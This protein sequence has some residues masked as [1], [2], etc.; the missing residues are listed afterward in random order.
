MEFEHK[1]EAQTQVVTLKNRKTLE[2]TGVK[3]IESLNSEEFFIHTNLGDMLVQGEGL[4]MQHL[5][6]EKG[7]LWISGLV[8]SIEYVEGVKKAKEKNSLLGKLFK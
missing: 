3:K 6:I 7:I 8:F 2:I 4:E 5:D 1:P